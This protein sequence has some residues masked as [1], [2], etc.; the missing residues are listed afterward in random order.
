MATS[1]AI[2]LITQL[3]KTHGSPAAAAKFWEIDASALSR[4]LNGHRNPR[5]STISKIAAKEKMDVRAFFGSAQTII[6]Q[7]LANE[8]EF[9]ALD[10]A[11]LANQM[12]AWFIRLPDR[13]RRRVI[14]DILRALKD[15]AF[16]ELN[17][18]PTSWSFVLRRYGD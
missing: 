12:E 17:P 3:V 6:G 1:T 9:H 4:I 10:P 18:P 7:S 11:S 16:N 15:E 13:V 5:P 8:F 2:S 14:R